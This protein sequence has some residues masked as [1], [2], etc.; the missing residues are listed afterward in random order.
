VHVREVE[1]SP[2]KQDV[3][4]SKEIWSVGIFSRIFPPSGNG[5]TV[6]N[7]IVSPVLEPNVLLVLVIVAVIGVGRISVTSEF[8]LI[9]LFTIAPEESVV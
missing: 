3:E 2:L 7:S 6:V 9:S 4:V 1:R 5:F 8:G